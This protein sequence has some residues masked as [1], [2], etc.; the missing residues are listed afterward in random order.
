MGLTTPATTGKR[1]TTYAFTEGTLST[2]RASESKLDA[3]ILFVL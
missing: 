1:S 3:Y 2:E